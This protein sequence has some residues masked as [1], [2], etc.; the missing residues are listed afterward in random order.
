MHKW[1]I[2]R[3]LNMLGTPS[4]GQ[5]LTWNNTTK[6]YEP[7]SIPAP[8]LAPVTGID[9]PATN[10]PTKKG[11]L[12]VADDLAVNVT[13]ELPKVPGNVKIRTSGADEEI[14]RQ[15]SDLITTDGAAPTTTD[16]PGMQF[17][18][19]ANEVVIVDGSIILYDVAGYNAA[20]VSWLVPE[21]CT[22]IGYIQRITN[23]STGVPSGGGWEPTT[24]PS[25]PEAVGE[26]STE[27]SP[28]ARGV[29]YRVDFYLTF[30]ND[31]NAGSVK[32]QFT[33]RSGDATQQ[34]IREGTFM[35]VDRYI[36]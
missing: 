20:C 33:N 24:D 35:R 13:Y 19:A 23:T 17:A 4:D 21:D 29:A 12:K 18:L 11:K 3:L 7:A 28:G 9:F 22:W 2:E 32:M 5:T 27:G 10:D 31:A 34:G 14:I 30:V 25:G 8:Q 6:S 15:T 16:V 26:I 36:D 1:V